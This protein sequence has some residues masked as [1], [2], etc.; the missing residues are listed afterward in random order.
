MSTN[1]DSYQLKWHS[2]TSHLNGS[3]AALFR[4]EKFTDVVLCTMDGYQIPAHKFILSSCSIYLNNVLES[5]RSSLRF[6]NTLIYVV[7]PPEITTKAL[8]ILIEY[9]YKGETTVSNDVLD[10]VLKAGDL[11]K[12]RGLWRQN[13]N[14][15][16]ALEER[17]SNEKR[18]PEILNKQTVIKKSD[19]AEASMPKISVKKDEKLLK[20]FVPLQQLNLSR[21]SFV[22][23]PKLVF[24]K[25]PDGNQTLR[26]IAPKPTP[27][28]IIVTPDLQ[29]HVTGESGKELHEGHHFIPEVKTKKNDKKYIKKTKFDPVRSEAD[30]S[31]DNKTDNILEM[32]KEDLDT[33]GDKLSHLIVKTEPEWE[34]EADMSDQTELFN[35]EIII[36]PEL[37]DMIGLPMEDDEID[38]QIYS[39]LTCEL[40]FEVFHIPAEWVRHIQGHAESTT[41]PTTRKRKARSASD[42]TEE[43]TALLRCDLCQKHFPNPAEWVRHIQNTHTETELAI[44]NNSAPPRRHNRYLEGDQNKTCDHCKKVFPS[45]ASMVIHLRTHTGERPFIC[46]LCNKGF[47]VKSNLLRH[48]R[49]L[50]DTIIGPGNVPLYQDDLIITATSP[51]SQISASQPSTSSDPMMEAPS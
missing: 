17:V 20:S 2:H 28:T 30:K 10:I 37:D 33:N 16:E 44:S 49:T 46:G 35:S 50:H 38:E 25:S 27:Q 11:L 40:C 31:K 43:T 14:Q 29:H 47:N 12:I 7:L 32:H 39:P 15:N 22:G 23:P 9:M 5:Q 34:D 21:Q 26:A 13:E 6:G 3:V 51:T 41:Q 48:L 19:S 18:S 45:H 42:D 4:S 8:Q 24:I 1:M 36:K